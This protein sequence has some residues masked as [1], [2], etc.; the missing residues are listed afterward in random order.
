M[1]DCPLGDE[2]DN[3]HKPHAIRTDQWVLFPDFFDAFTPR[4]REYVFGLVF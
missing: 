1:D 2:R 4:E 3:S